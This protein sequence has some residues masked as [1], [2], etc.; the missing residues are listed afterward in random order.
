MMSDFV[1]N[2]FFPFLILSPNPSVLH[3]STYMG[4]SKSWVKSRLTELSLRI[5]RHKSSS[6]NNNRFKEITWLPTIYI[7]TCETKKRLNFHTGKQSNDNNEKNFGTSKSINRMKFYYFF[8][9]NLKEKTF[10]CINNKIPFF[11]YVF[12]SQYYLFSRWLKR[13][14]FRLGGVK[15]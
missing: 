12:V 1:V 11:F 9:I 8:I 15:V 14:Q 4:L 7:K 13:C 10:W 5:P 2:H 6:S 3:F